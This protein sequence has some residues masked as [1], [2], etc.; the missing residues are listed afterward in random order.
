MAE[1]GH[2]DLKLVWAATLATAIFW[3]SPGITFTAVIAVAW[4]KCTYGTLSC[5]LI[6]RGNVKAIAQPYSIT[7]WLGEGC[8]DGS[9]KG[10]ALEGAMFNRSQNQWLRGWSQAN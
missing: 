1:F 3:R 6:Y 7:Q 5:S 4:V 8:Y 9:I 2:T 10:Y